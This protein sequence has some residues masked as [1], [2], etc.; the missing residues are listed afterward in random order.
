MR[1]TGA[2]CVVVSGKRERREVVCVRLR[3]RYPV[4]AALPVTE[5]YLDGAMCDA[6]VD[7]GCSHCI[8]YAP[9]CASWTRAVKGN[10]VKVLAVLGSAFVTATLWWLMFM[11]LVSNH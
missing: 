10:V 9:C 7:S 8:V 5:R 11:L 2:L 4:N 3:P 6:L 1:W